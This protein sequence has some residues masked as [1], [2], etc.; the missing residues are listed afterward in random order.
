MLEE[1]ATKNYAHDIRMMYDSPPHF[2]KPDGSGWEI[3]EWND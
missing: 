3:T 1:R 2:L